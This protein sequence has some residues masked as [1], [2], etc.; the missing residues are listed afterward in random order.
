MDEYLKKDRHIQRLNE[1]LKRDADLSLLK[2]QIKGLDS[3]EYFDDG[4]YRESNG[5]IKELKF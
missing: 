5:G 3:R 4:E 1:K 2:I